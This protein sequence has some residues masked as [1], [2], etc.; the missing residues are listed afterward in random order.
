MFDVCAFDALE[1]LAALIFGV[2]LGCVVLLVCVVVLVRWIASLFMFGDLIVGVGL[3][4]FR[5]L[6]FALWVCFCILLVYGCW[7]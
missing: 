7:C 6:W 1:F 4:L 2:L 5:V 3:L